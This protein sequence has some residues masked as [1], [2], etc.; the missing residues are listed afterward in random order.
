[1]LELPSE[2]QWRC[3]GAHHPY[4]DEWRALSDKAADH[5]VVCEECGLFIDALV[6]PPTSDDQW[7]QQLQR[8]RGKIL[9]EKRCP[10]HRLLGTEKFALG[11]ESPPES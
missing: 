6:I 7:E 10:H 5:L 9:Q 3:S 2:I 4:W 1:M 11:Q 8:I